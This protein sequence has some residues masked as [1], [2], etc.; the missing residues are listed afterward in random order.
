MKTRLLPARFL[1]SLL[2]VLL[3]SCS[4]TRYTTAPAVEELTHYVLV[5]FHPFSLVEPFKEWRKKQEQ[6][7]GTEEPEPQS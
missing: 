1:A 2:G 4:A 5:I 6:E 3:T 7:Q